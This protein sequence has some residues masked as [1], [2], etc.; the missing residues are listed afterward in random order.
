MSIALTESATLHPF[1]PPARADAAD[2]GELREFVAVRNEIY[3]AISGRT[4]QDMTAAELLPFLHADDDQDR[5]IWKVRI[6]GEMVG[7]ALLNLPTEQDSRS[8]FAVLELHPS[9]W[10]QG[11]GSAILPHLE[12]ASRDRGR[13]VLQ[14][15]A[16]QPKSDAPRLPSPTGFGSVPHDH[17]ARFLLRHGFAL[18]QVER[19]STLE[20]DEPTLARAARLL[21]DAQQAASEYRVVQWTLPTPPE[22]VAGYAALKSG[23]STDVPAAELVIDPEM[24]DADRVARHDRRFIDGGRTLQVTA[25]EHIA[26]G[27]LCAFNELVIGADRSA[28]TQQEDT[29]VLKEHRGHRLG[30][31]VK[32]AALLSWRDIAPQSPRVITY[33]A[34]ENR[35]MLSINEAI[36]FAPIAYEGA[37]KKVLT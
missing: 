24:W 15:W 13:D 22:R 25:A 8:A 20:L 9:V 1:V 27:Q 6:G 34:E 32:C 12:A 2:G 11:I 26:T 35:P 33:N 14:V 19:V 31:L 4:D 36:G 23:M 3:R 21:A 16:E 29:L 18:E 37:W 17:V 7:R 10:G 30:M 5:L 28:V